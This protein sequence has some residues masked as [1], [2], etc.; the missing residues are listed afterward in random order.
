MRALFTEYAAA[1]RFINRQW[2]EAMGSLPLA[3]LDRPQ[4]AF[5]DSIFGTW[6]HL[7]I[8]DRIWMARI[9]DQPVPYDNLRHRAVHTW[10]DLKRERVATDEDLIRMIADEKD[11]ERILAY[12]STAGAP[13]KTPLYQIL[14]HLF[15]HEG[16]HRGQISQMCHE[17]KLAMP[18]G[19]LIE[20]Y[21]KLA[22]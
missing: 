14:A 19:G 7:L 2:L 17:R 4:G 21:R 22:V 9:R 18:D 10:D 13:Y 8:T 3:E 5:F 16:H 15:A 12:R 11:F 20:F 6:N 1:N